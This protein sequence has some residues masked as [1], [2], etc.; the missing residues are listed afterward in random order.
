MV[1][2]KPE[3]KIFVRGGLPKVYLKDRLV[4]ANSR[5]WH[6]ILD[7]L[8]H[9]KAARP[10]FDECSNRSKYAEEER[11][12]IDWSIDEALKGSGIGVESKAKAGLS[13]HRHFHERPRT[14]GRSY[15]NRRAIF[16]GNF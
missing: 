2:N 3:R 1:G 5:N 4:Y 9:A 13:L 15:V 14:S 7:T 16:T 6:C 8:W 12:Y 10:Y 11:V